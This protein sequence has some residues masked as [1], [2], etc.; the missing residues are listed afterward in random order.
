MV[1][2]TGALDGCEGVRVAPAYRPRPGSGG[3]ASRQGSATIL[4]QFAAGDKMSALRK[5]G[6]ALVRASPLCAHSLAR[7]C[8]HAVL[9][10]ETL[11]HS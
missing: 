3:K 5:G 6:R 2:R 1:A 8:Q 10:F 9:P 7:A 4:A 11:S